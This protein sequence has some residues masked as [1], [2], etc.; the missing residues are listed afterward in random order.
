MPAVGGSV[1]SVSIDGRTFPVAADAEANRNLGGFSN[2]VE[3]NG[4]GSSRIIKTREQ[5]R[6]E[7]L[8]VQIDDD[9]GD[10]E[11]LQEVANGRE[12]VVIAVT[13]AN[14]ET[15]QGRAQLTGDMQTNTQNATMEI[16]LHGIG[17]FT[18]Q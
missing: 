15:Y 11:F 14:G 9:R 6:Y 2:E 10:Q 16:N 5:P 12:F 1:E 8:T 3:P 4:D 7:G 17:R 18:Q 13:H